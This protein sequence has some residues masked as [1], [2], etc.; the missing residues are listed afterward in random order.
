MFVLPRVHAIIKGSNGESFRLYKDVM[1]A[2]PKWVEDSAY[3]RA[4]VQD[5]KLVVSDST[6][7]KVVEAKL[8]TA[9]KISAEKNEATIEAVKAEPKKT[10]SKK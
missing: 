5:G 2:V 3:F 6:K 1:G 9:E 7:D 4:L 10:R 8:E